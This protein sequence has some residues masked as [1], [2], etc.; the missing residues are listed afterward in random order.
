MEIRRKRILVLNGATKRA[1]ML[2]IKKNSWEDKSVEMTEHRAAFSSVWYRGELIVISGNIPE[3]AMGSVERYNPFTDTWHPMPSLPQ[4]LRYA[5]GAVLHNQLYVIGGYNKTTG[6]AT[7]AVYRYEPMGDIPTKNTQQVTADG[8][9]TTAGAGEHSHNGYW[10]LI[11]IPLPSSRYTHATIGFDGKIWVAGGFPKPTSVQIFDPLLGD[12]SEGPPLM[13]RRAVFKLLVCNG[14][15]FAVGGD[16]AASGVTT[17]EKFDRRTQRW[18]IITHMKEQ[19]IMFSATV[20]GSKIYVFGGM[21][22]ST[23]ALDTWDAFDVRTSRWDSD[24]GDDGLEH[25]R[26]EHDDFSEG[27]DYCGV[28]YDDD[29]DFDI[30]FEM[31]STPQVNSPSFSP[32]LPVQSGSSSQVTSPLFVAGGN[33]TND[34]STST[35]SPS[36]AR[37]NDGH[38]HVPVPGSLKRS[39]SGT[40]SGSLSNVNMPVRSSSFQAGLVSPSFDKSCTPI[41]AS[42]DGILMGSHESTPSLTTPSSFRRPSKRAR[43]SHRKKRRMVKIERKLPFGHAFGCAITIPAISLYS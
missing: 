19:R 14:D 37:G 25:E 11:D 7:S 43:R 12:W 38:I 30:D 15:L 5:S 29:N 21:M 10:N 28:G 24:T 6:V 18:S 8:V 33:T 13:V 4:R 26:D 20:A 22:N 36:P 42:S 35:F 9:V 34:R 32:Q 17:I 3:T 27:D 39:L 16:D 1:A 41:R 2:D 40:F 23:I 31:T